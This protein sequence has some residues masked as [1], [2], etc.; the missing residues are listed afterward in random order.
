MPDTKT[1]RRS[2]DVALQE[3]AT[4]QDIARHHPSGDIT[5]DALEA[6]FSGHCAPTLLVAPESGEILYVNRAA[7]LMYGYGA[8]DLLGMTVETLSA[9]PAEKVRATRRKALRGDGQAVAVRHRLANGCV[10]ELLAHSSPVQVDGQTRLLAVMLDVTPLHDARK[11]LAVRQEQLDI[12]VSAANAGVVDV[13]LVNGEIQAS[14]T[15]WDLLGIARDQFSTLTEFTALLHPDDV[16]AAIKHCRRSIERRERFE[17]RVRLR[18]ADGHYTWVLG[19]ARAVYDESGEAVRYVGS[20]RDISFTMRIESD[21]RASERRYR[22]MFEASPVPMLVVDERLER[23]Q[24]ANFAAM[25][26]YE[27][28]RNEVVGCQLSRLL[29]S[30]EDIAVLSR[31][32]TR[33]EMRHRS[34]SGRILDVNCSCCSVGTKGR[35]AN[36]LMVE[37]L[38]RQ[39]ADACEI[40]RLATVDEVTGLHNR[41]AFESHLA[42]AI[43]RAT[44]M[45]KS[46]ALLVVNLDSFNAVNSAA[47]RL[48]A[49][50][51][52]FETGQRLVRVAG[53]NDSLAR[54]QGDEF[55]LVFH[56]MHEDADRMAT[57]AG[58]LAHDIVAALREPYQVDDMAFT[59]TASVGIA[60]FG[61]Q[62]KQ[63]MTA[64]NVLRHCE[65]AVRQAKQQGGDA[66]RYFD[67][68]IQRDLDTRSA[69]ELDLRR[70]VNESQF[71]LYYQLQVDQ[72][73]RAVG[74]EVLLRWNHPTRGVV[75]P[76]QFIDLAEETGVII[77]LG[78]W[79]LEQACYTLSRWAGMPGYEHLSL[80]V[81]VS[82][83]Q[84]RQADFVSQVT[85]ALTDSGAR[86]ELLTLE[87]TESLLLDY[88]D[89]AIEKMHD[90]RVLGIGFS[91]DDFGTGYSSLAYLKRLPLDELKIDR[92]FIRDI[93]TDPNDAIIVR[94]II[95]MANNLGLT[96]IAEGVESEAQHKTLTR[97]GC[98]GFQGYHFARPM[99]AG[100]F[101][102]QPSG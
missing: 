99:P 97:W 54:Q 27:M 28:D 1:R 43:E 60:L 80:S 4:S 33:V 13:N 84:F 46:G 52:L 102:V 96:L 68:D 100:A 35:S 19:S 11:A 69:L 56:G 59:L 92:G 67:P 32:D 101:S 98:T 73:A 22:R 58:R 82:A 47:G 71:E 76:L 62:P 55:A 30:D 72:H 53:V 7:E 75:S 90:L 86:P 10:H 14:D 23:I 65:S 77:S 26:L 89:Q 79:V 81:N 31:G 74:A 51:I 24:E 87:I 18:R 21:L 8:A 78:Q 61:G 2:R 95:G 17:R 64:D 25:D 91:L 39:K 3:P 88:A 36:L 70:A 38:T 12:V 66:F 40:R 49:D 37:D 85:R 5:M 45:G 16:D 83:R 94:T 20:I 63:A 29:A 44:S 6:M 9:E 57:Q 50:Q 15:V 93:L 42:S 48:V 34:S 41:A